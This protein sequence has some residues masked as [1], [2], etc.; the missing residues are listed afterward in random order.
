MLP[1]IGLILGFDN[2]PT[3]RP[4]PTSNTAYYDKSDIYIIVSI[5]DGEIV[6]SKPEN[7]IDDVASVWIIKLDNTTAYSVGDFVDKDGN[8]I[9]NGDVAYKAYGIANRLFPD[10][11]K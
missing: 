10:N 9:I 4:R 5:F 2:I 11:I 6:V 1:I 8:L 7:V 3:S